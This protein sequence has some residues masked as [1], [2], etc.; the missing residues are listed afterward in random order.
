M[1]LQT[2]RQTDVLQG[3]SPRVAD[4]CV[5]VCVSRWMGESVQCLPCLGLIFLQFL[6]Q[7]ALSIPTCKT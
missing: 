3:A 2:D 7:R 6:P 4:Q 1:E 5:A